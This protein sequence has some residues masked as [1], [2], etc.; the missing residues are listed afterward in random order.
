MDGFSPAIRARPEIL[1]GGDSRSLTLAVLPFENASG[2]RLRTGDF[3]ELL[4]TATATEMSE[5]GW[6][7]EDG[8]RGA[9]A[10]P[11]SLGSLLTQTPSLAWRFSPRT[12]NQQ[13]QDRR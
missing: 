12:P 3:G 2:F 11:R 9:C 8:D 4:A 13:P 5:G 6:E 1:G 7:R 10:M